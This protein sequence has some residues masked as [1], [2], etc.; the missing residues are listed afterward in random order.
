MLSIPG[1]GGRPITV[2]QVNIRLAAVRACD[3][4]FGVI[5]ARSNGRTGGCAGQK[6]P[7][8][9]NPQVAAPHPRP[10]LPVLPS[11]SHL[12]FFSPPIFFL[13]SSSRLLS[14][15]LLFC[16]PFFLLLF[17]CFFLFFFCF[18]AP[19]RMFFL[20]QT[21]KSSYKR[22]RIW[23]THRGGGTARGRP[24]RYPIGQRG[25]TSSFGKP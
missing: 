22:R 10:F 12:P 23:N 13:I 17:R 4:P 9:Y 16:S 5:I 24:G 25:S 20:S 18:C 7:C 15:S 19:A 2:V 8:P 6:E 11:L 14:S 3:G 1:Q 21:Q